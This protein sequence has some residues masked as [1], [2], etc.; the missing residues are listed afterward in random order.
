[1]VGARPQFIK[2]APLSRAL[3]RRVREVLVHTGQHY[4]RDMSEAFFEELGIPAPDRHLG[5]GSGSHG[6]MTGRMLE[7]LEAVMREVG[8]DLVVVL[9]D[10]NSTLAGALAAAKLGIPVAHVEAGLRSF[11]AAMP[12]EINR[13]LTDHVS[14]L[15]FCPS[16]TA[17][18]NLRAEGITRGVHR[19]GDVMMDAVRQNLARARRAGS[20]PGAPAPR[21]Y[22]LATLHR[23]ENVDD[24]RRLA[25]ILRAL[26]SLSHPTVLPVHPRTRK[27]ISGLGLRPAGRLHLRAP[28]TYLEM[29]SLEAGARAVLTDSG[30]VQKEAFILGTPCVTLRETTEWVETLERGANRLV[31]ADPARIQRA[32]R[33][34]ECA[35][36]RWSPG[37]VYGRGRAAE[38]VA[39]VVSGFLARSTRE[40]VS[41]GGR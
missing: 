11:D 30:G 23:Q 12:E 24:P 1:V 19:V 20:R 38:A 34:I 35:R 9:G 6:A 5:I 26:A 37:R 40:R 27:A 22:Y 32:V 33:Q 4:D 17:L 18:A 15:L 7:A 13:R 3:R 41:R 39:R 10:T 2:A 36:P 21:S 28:A 31:G 29:L 8:P 25:S 16:P 14:R